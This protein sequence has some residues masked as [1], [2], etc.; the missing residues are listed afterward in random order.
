MATRPD[1]ICHAVS[2]LG[3]GRFQESPSSEP[4]SFNNGGIIVKGGDRY[5]FLTLETF[6]RHFVLEDGQAIETVYQIDMQT[7][8]K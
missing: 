2:V 5:K 6:R 4:V 3:A 7:P 8:K 1:I